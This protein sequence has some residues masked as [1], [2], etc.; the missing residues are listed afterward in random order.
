MLGETFYHAG[1]GAFS[2][3]PSYK[4]LGTQALVLNIDT[5]HPHP[6]TDL[7][8]YFSLPPPPTTST[9]PPLQ[10][11]NPPLFPPH[12]LSP[13]KIRPHLLLRQPIRPISGRTARPLPEPVMSFLEHTLY[14]PSPGVQR[15]HP[16]SAS[17]PGAVVFLQ[18]WV[19]ALSRGAWLSGTVY[20]LWGTRWRFRQGRC[21]RRRGS[22]RRI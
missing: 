22:E 2:F 5:A 10:L 15:R 11:K 14:I 19:I 21:F 6:T 18:E 13:L 16:R 9:P 7:T 4:R 8:P 3:S 12:A 17:P 20:L 1:C